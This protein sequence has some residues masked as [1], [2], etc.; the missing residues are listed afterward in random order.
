ME[1]RKCDC[2]TARIDGP[3]RQLEF[4]HLG[5]ARAPNHMVV[6]KA[7]GLHES[8]NNRRPAELEPGLLEVLADLL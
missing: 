7:A 8:I 1:R 6:N 2:R 3:S 4:L 5:V